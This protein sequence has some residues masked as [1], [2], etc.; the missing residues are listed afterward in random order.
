MD[1]ARE[2]KA[3]WVARAGAAVLIVLVAAVALNGYVVVVEIAKAGG[4]FIDQFFLTLI[5]G[6]VAAGAAAVATSGFQVRGR[7]LV[8]VEILTV[9]AIDSAQVADV[10]DFAGLTVVTRTGRRVQPYVCGRSLFKQLNQNSR[11]RASGEA[12]RIWAAA[13]LDDD[14][15]HAPTTVERRSLRWIVL[16]GVPAWGALCG[17]LTVALHAAVH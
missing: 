8:A 9:S 3:Q 16:L 12:I 11:L 5:C 15:D 7:T 17:V 4:F 14:V 13:H 10:E 6:L 2:D 1:A